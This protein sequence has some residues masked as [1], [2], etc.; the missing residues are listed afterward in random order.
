LTAINGEN[1]LEVLEESYITVHNCTGL[2]SIELN[3]MR[4][5]PNPGDGHF[6][7]SL[8]DNGTYEVQIFD[9]T[10]QEVYS[11]NLSAEL[12]QLDISHLNNGVYILNANNGSAQFKERVVIK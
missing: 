5:S 10:G 2:G 3:R 6:N 4:I 8:P 1:Q 11:T 9:I 7:I 12:N